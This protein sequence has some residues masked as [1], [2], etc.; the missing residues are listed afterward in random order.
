MNIFKSFQLR[1]TRARPVTAVVVET[2]NRISVSFA[3]PNIVVGH[4][5]T[6]CG[7]FACSLS[8]TAFCGSSS[9]RIYRTL[10]PYAGGRKGAD[11][12]QLGQHV[13]S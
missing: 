12:L 13:C 10:K 9:C 5:V 8:D 1:G 2:V 11:I 4:F 6:R 7:R 3:K